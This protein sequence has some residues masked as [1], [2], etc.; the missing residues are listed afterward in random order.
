MFDQDHNYAPPDVMTRRVSVVTVPFNIK[1]GTF[2][3]PVV[4]GTVTHMAMRG[5]T[6][7][8]LPP[9]PPE[10]GAQAWIEH[11]TANVGDVLPMSEVSPLVETA[12][13]KEASV[14]SYWKEHKK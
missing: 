14:R 5:A 11:G 13:A 7:I 8:D 4:A 3:Y 2:T 1:V 12:K 9:K 10:N 6:H